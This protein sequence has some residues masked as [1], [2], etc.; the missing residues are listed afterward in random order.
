ML[1]YACLTNQCYYAQNYASIMCQGLMAT[2]EADILADIDSDCDS[3]NSDSEVSKEVSV[4]S[5]LD[6]LK[7]PKSSDLAR[8]R[9]V[10]I[11]PPK[12]KKKSK[13]G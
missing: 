5:L 12:G 3:S 7:C 4:P 6:R 2:S 13:G 9:K 11:N 10:L 8:K 1:D